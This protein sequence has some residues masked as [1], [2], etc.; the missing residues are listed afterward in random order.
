MKNRQ[1]RTDNNIIT[2]ILRFFIL[3][4]FYQFFQR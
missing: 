3:K 2:F 1:E 4:M